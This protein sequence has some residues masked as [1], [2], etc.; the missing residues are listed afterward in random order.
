MTSKS[1]GY[2]L[3]LSKPRLKAPRDQDLDLQDNKQVYL[4]P[5]RIIAENIRGSSRMRICI[6]SDLE[7][8]LP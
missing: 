4:N 1:Y 6:L 8:C 7:I 5:Q 2:D 3:T